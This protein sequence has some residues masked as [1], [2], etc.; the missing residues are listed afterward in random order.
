MFQ[1][2]VKL[3]LTQ[4][5]LK[6]KKRESTTESIENII[7]SLYAK[8]MSNS[9]IENKLSFPTDEAVMKSVFL[10]LRKSTK[11]WTMPIRNWGVILNQISAI[12]ENRIKL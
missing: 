1:K 2:T 9:D 3:A 7:I 6:T 12:F 5:L 10:A 11:K 8:R 4:W